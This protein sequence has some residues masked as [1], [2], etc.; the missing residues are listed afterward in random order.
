MTLGKVDFVKREQLIDNMQRADPDDL[1]NAI[2]QLRPIVLQKLAI[3]WNI[4]RYETSGFRKE[5]KLQVVGEKD[6]YLI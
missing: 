2:H 3:S 1:C 5:A 4:S 6:L